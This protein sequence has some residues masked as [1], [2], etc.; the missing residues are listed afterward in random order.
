MSHYPWTK[1]GGQIIGADGTLTPV[2]GTPFNTGE[3]SLAGLV[4]S[5]VTFPALSCPRR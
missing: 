1:D 2:P 4:E 5:V 3:N